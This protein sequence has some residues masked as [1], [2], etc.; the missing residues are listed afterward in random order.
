MAFK[1]DLRASVAE[2]VYGEPLEI[3]CE[4]LAPTAGPVNAVHLITELRQHMAHLRLVP[5]AL[6]V[7]PATFVH[8]DLEKCTHVYL[9]HDAIRWALE[10][11]Y[12]GH[13]QVLS[14]REKTLRLLVR[15]RSVTVS[16]DRVKPVYMLNETDRGTTTAHR[17][18]YTFRTPHTF[19]CS[20]KHLSDNLR[21]GGGD[22]GAT[23]IESSVSEISADHGS[24]N[25]DWLRTTA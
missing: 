14:R 17:T 5:A 18:D 4:L 23:R 6:H 11:S 7:S 15:G 10:P 16:T 19:P 3:P 2:L 22:A 13:Y 9:H 1:D 21:G 24:S 8:S 25:A 20:L 12:S